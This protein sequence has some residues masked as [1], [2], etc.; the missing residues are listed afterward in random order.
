MDEWLKVGIRDKTAVKITNS[1]ELLHL[2]AHTFPVPR[3]PKVHTFRLNKHSSTDYQENPTRKLKAR[4]SPTH[5]WTAKSWVFEIRQR[6][7]RDFY[8]DEAN[9][10]ARMQQPVPATVW[11]SWGRWTHLGCWGSW[12]AW[13]PRCTSGGPS[14][15]TSPSSP[16][17]PPPAPAP[18]PWLPLSPPRSRSVSRLLRLTVPCHKNWIFAGFLDRLGLGHYWFCWHIRGNLRRFL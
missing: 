15:A 12:D 17:P 18:P 6:T 3:T 5:E 13:W 16:P 14:S 2:S 1:S 10:E 11:R 8:R 9:E 7:K 4:T